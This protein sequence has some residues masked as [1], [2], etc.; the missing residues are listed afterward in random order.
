MPLI[1]LAYSNYIYSLFRITTIHGL[2]A[3][4]TGVGGYC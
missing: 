1:M 4:G 2:H 3:R